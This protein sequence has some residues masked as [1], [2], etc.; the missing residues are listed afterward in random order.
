VSSGHAISTR[1]DD[2]DLYVGLCGRRRRSLVCE[3]GDGCSGVDECGM[4]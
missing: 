2:G 4:I 3:E 1:L